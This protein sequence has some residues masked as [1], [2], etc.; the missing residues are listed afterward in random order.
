MN[1]FNAVL[2][3]PTR[4][5]LSFPKTVRRA[6][7]TR[8]FYANQRKLENNHSNR[9]SVVVA[10]SKSQI[11]IEP[12]TEVASAFSP[13]TVA[14]LGSGFD[15]MGC[16]VEGQGD[17]VT[18]HLRTDIPGQVVIEG[19]SGDDGR[20][21]LETLENCSG[22][23]AVETLKLLGVRDVGVSL[24]LRKGLPLGSGLGSSA[25]SAAAAAWAVN[26]LF[27]HPLS[28]KQL[29]PAGL[30]SEA[31]VSGY[32]ADNI[33]PA[34]M[35]GF[36]LIRSYEPTLELLHLHPP[37][38]LWFTVVTPVFEAPTR[39]MRAV[40][41]TTIPFK[42][43]TLNATATA[44]L[45][46]GILTGDVDLLGQ[47]LNSDVIVEPARGPLI[48]GFAA[49]KRAAIESGACGC[50]ISGAGPTVVAV[51]K[52]RETGVKA[53]KAMVSAFE[54]DGNLAVNCAA[55]VTLCDAGAH[56]CDGAYAPSCSSHVLL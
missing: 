20:L 22:I 50:T 37:A 1:S 2:E 53:A 52:D 28:Q 33:A 17:V 45:V 7:N 18:A 43:H 34:L 14:N 46:A 3:N 41:P 42:D 19:I 13:A 10:S 44:C 30:V 9:Y 8:R 39:Q 21:S 56:D 26:A 25:A 6:G 23:A 31:K 15:F 35:G 29:V 12:V 11:L 24:T 36:V 5:Y 51:C 47:G 27:G 4:P 32:H 40:L 49:V 38:P 55:V 16:A 54:K 48:P